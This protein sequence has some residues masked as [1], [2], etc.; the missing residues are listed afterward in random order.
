M[1]NY[2]FLGFAIS[3]L[4]TMTGA[5]FKIQSWEGGGIFLTVGFISFPL[6]LIGYFIHKTVEAKKARG[7]T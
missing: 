4:F 1:K 5:L 2:L 3:L 7:I 6:I